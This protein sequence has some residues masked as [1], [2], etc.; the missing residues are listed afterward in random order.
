MQAELRAKILIVDDREENLVAL[1]AALSSPDYDIDRAGSGQEALKHLLTSDYAVILLDVQMPELDGFETAKIIKTR[2]RS[3]DIPIIFV[4]AISREETFVDQGYASGA[5]DYILKPFDPKILRSKVQIFVDLFRKSALRKVQSERLRHAD[6]LER[7]NALA[8]LELENLRR[9]RSLADSV[10][11]IV[12]KAQS[13]N[14]IDHFNL[15]WCDYTGLSQEASNGRGW[16]IAVFAADCEN[17]LRVWAAAAEYRESFDLE[18][19]IRRFD[20]VYRSHL[21]RAVCE[22][23]GGESWIVTCTDIDDRKR[24]EQAQQ[25]LASASV[26]LSSSL[27]ADKMLVQIGDLAL[28]GFADGCIMRLIAD[29]EIRTVSIRHRQPAIEDALKALEAKADATSGRGFRGRVVLVT[30]ETESGEGGREFW[31]RESPEIRQLA[32]HLVPTSYIA[33]PFRAGGK[34]QGSLELMAVR[35]FFSHDDVAIATALAERV[36]LALE[37][38][39]L[40]REATVGRKLAEG[41]NRSKDEFLAMLSHE[42]RTP[43]NAI[44][45]WVQLLRSGDIAESERERGLEVIE[46][47]TKS[48]VR[49]IDDLLDVSRIVSG[50]LRIETKEADPVPVVL[51]AVE[52]MRPL[53]NKGELQLRCAIRASGMN[54]MADTGKLQQIITNLLSNAVK[55]TPPHGEVEVS[56]DRVDGHAVISVRDTGKG[57]EQDFLPHVFDRF[58]QADSSITRQHGGLGLGLAIVHHLI[59]L[60]GGEVTAQSDGVGHGTCF[61]VRL[62]LAKVAQPASSAPTP[63]NLP[64]NL[65]GTQILLVDDEDDSREM[66]RFLLEKAGAIVT[67]A[68][69]V[70]EALAAMLE[71]KPDVLVS[72]IGMPGE[73]GYKLIREIRSRPA[74]DGGLV[75]AIAVTAFARDEERRQVLLAGYHRHLAKPI[76]SARLVAMISELSPRGVAALSVVPTAQLGSS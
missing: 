40:Y 35:S 74:S 18:V 3:R 31:E 12:W 64:A 4:T 72:D 37:N 13:P 30:G 59:D 16:Q 10:P 9:Y 57:I 1:D 22:S 6:R 71:H 61:T 52:S 73:D 17:L 53:A 28:C 14:V 23:G 24:V 69:S 75:P 36:S 55:F 68:S 49:L 66:V 8:R 29:G 33:V 32:E 60:H 58:R 11:H 2:E 48:Q 67:T 45:G 44:L 46:R 42:L 56:V 63:S 15:L 19:R 76:D 62:P 43:I 54:V 47:N 50:K 51:A 41:A 27:D 25:F 5:V 7:E 39:R 21:L 34:M 26:V 38:A 70:R 65:T 20:G